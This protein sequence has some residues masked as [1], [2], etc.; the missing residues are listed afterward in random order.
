MKKER[1]KLLL[2]II[3]LAIIF[4]CK[5]DDTPDGPVTP[6][7]RDKKEVYAE[8]I[9]AIE[10]YLKTHTFNYE[11]FDFDNP[12]AESNDGFKIVFDTLDVKKTPEK[13]PLIDF[14]E[15]KTVKDSDIDYKLYI[16]KLR[17]GKGDSLH[18]LDQFISGIEGKLLNNNVFF[19]SSEF[20]SSLLTVPGTVGVVKGLREAILEFNIATG[21][22]ERDNG[23]ITQKEQGIGAVF[24]PSGL[25][26]FSLQRGEIPAYSP[27]IFKF[28]IYGKTYSDF[29]K[30][31]IP[32]HIENPKEDENNYIDTDGDSTPDIVD[33]D[34]DNDGVV[35]DQ[36]IDKETIT[37][38][39]KEDIEAKGK[40]LPKN[41]FLINITKIK[42][43]D[44]EGEVLVFKDENENGIYDHLDKDYPEEQ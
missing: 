35:T 6:T 3:V 34:D 13:K 1:F 9:K 26:Y 38:T 28:D 12:Y 31:K 25:A 32:S 23:D 20:K 2:G 39:S 22:I 24:I 5:K 21:Y 37:G 27:L 11:T 17:E 15:T 33:A 19:K 36:E 14:V 41:K 30:D 16:L 10:D 40:N 8:D 43:G 44:F 42:E 7:A 4:G 29:D 18:L